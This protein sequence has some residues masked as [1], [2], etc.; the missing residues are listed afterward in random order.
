MALN[1]NYPVVEELWGPSWTAAGASFPAS[2]MVNFVDRTLSQANARRGK[3][4]ELDQP[5]A[6][7]YSVVLDSR[8]GTLDPTNTGGAYGG[9]ILPYQPYRRRA[10]WPPSPNVLPS[11]VATAGDGFLAGTIPASFGVTVPSGSVTGSIA[12]LGVG[13]AWQGSNVFSLAIS[14]GTPINSGIFRFDSAA[15]RPGKKVTFSLYVANTTAGTSQGILPHIDWLAA[16]G[17][18]VFGSG[19]N[20]TIV[21]ASGTP[22]WQRLSVTATAPTTGNVYGMRIG[23]NLG[24]TA[25]A[26]STVIFDGLQVEWASAASTWTGPGTWYPIFTGFTERW[27]TQWANEG[28]YEE[29]TPTAVDAFALLS[30]VQLKEVFQEEIDSHSPRFCYPLGDAVGSTSF[31]DESGNFRALPAVMSKTGNG[32]LSAGNSV[33][34]ASAT[35]AYTGS[36]GTVATFAPPLP[37]NAN[38]S[39]ATVLDLTA[40][41]INGPGNPSGWTRMVAFRATSLPPDRLVI[42]ETR[43]DD[44]GD[45]TFDGHIRVSIGSDGWL[46]V[47]ANANLTD[48]NFS[49]AFSSGANVADGNW[50][51]FMFGFDATHFRTSLD[52]VQSTSGSSGLV[53][54]NPPVDC[55]GALWTPRTKSATDA[56]KGDLAFAT[57]FSTLLSEADMSQLYSTWKSSASGESS[58]ARYSRILRYAGYAGATNIGTGLTT[59]MGPADSLSGADAMSALNDVVTTENGEHFV[60]ADGT[61]VFRGRGVRYNALTPALTFGD[62]PGELPYEDLQLDF[63]STHLSN[64]VTV[65]QGPTGNDF[66]ASDA[67]S[68]AAYYTRSL[69][70]SINT[71]SAF[72]SQDAANY[73]VSRYKQPL[74]RVQSIKLHPSANTALWAPLL[75]L[76]LGTRVRINR[77]PFGAPMVSIDCFVEQISWDMNADNDAY[78]TLQ[79]SPIDASPYGEFAPWHTTLNTPASIGVT[80]II[81]NA[82]ADNVNPLSAQLPAG[83][84]LILGLGTANQ[85][86]VTVAGISGTSSGWTTALVGLTV[87]TTKAHSVGD[88]ICEALPS[89]VT[90]PAYLDSAEKFGTAIFAY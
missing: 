64:S 54:T 67:A 60:S 59:S 56:F 27:A 55:L 34:S 44:F 86:T 1:P 8:D 63:D 46:R 76:E 32:F 17:T 47:N 83:T 42:W 72:E 4:Y 41:G 48:Y 85:E 30:Q 77:R 35:G 78:V 37:G 84:Q 74:T 89:G 57:E 10:M 80:S 21:G 70:R 58:N 7:E 73:F 90:D 43:T 24:A 18:A 87:A 26:A 66:T 39:P 88:V 23:V 82:S 6:G 11:E 40:V 38:V 13:Q 20:T 51:L 81:V 2:R 22:S 69:T 12:A 25:T 79:C 71:T 19:S 16:D 68:I 28:T 52:G 36:T 33:T 9:K 75:A 5:Q 61:I 45:G 65:T 15:I 49:L 3:Q 14:N 62:G 31:V 29:V 50:H 53:M